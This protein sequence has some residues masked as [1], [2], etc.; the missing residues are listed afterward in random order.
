MIND[1]KFGISRDGPIAR[2][3]I[4]NHNLDFKILDLK[5]DDKWPKLWYLIRHG[6]IARVGIQNLNLDFKFLLIRR[7]MINDQYFGI[8]FV[9]G[10][11][12]ELGFKIKIWI[13]KS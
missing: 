13:S 8:S 12:P 5:V 6:P 3:G 1:Q 10:P 4:E 2:V 7:S 11:L 9:T